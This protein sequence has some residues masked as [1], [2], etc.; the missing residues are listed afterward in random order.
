M[1]TNPA[2][3]ISV[4]A[5]IPLIPVAVR[6]LG[7][8]LGLR[9]VLRASRPEE[10]PALLAAF[11]PITTAIQTSGRTHREYCSGMSSPALLPQDADAGDPSPEPECLGSHAARGRGYLNAA[12]R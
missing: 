6:T 1:W 8:L 4:A 2:T 3:A 10:R 11:V 12:S 9:M 7:W 5:L